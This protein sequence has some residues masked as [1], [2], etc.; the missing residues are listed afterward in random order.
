MN[1][2]NRRF[3]ERFTP[4]LAAEKSSVVTSSVRRRSLCICLKLELTF[5]QALGRSRRDPA[6]GA[7]VLYRDPAGA[8]AGSALDI[9]L[10]LAPFQGLTPYQTLSCCWHIFRISQSPRGACNLSKA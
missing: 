3:E 2:A 5:L 4:L 1:F 7:R 6:V 9:T 10:I 8:P